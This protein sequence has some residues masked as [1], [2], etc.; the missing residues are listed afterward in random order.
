METAFEKFDADDAGIEPRRHVERV[1]VG[2]HMAQ[3]IDEIRCISMFGRGRIGGEE[4]VCN[5]KIDRDVT[6]GGDTEGFG[7]VAGKQSAHPV[8]VEETREE[9]EDIRIFVDHED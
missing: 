7:S 3:T 1:K 5:N 6:A 2:A 9:R 4:D 8:G